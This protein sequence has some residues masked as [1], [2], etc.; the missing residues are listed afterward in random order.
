MQNVTSE[1]VTRQHEDRP[2]W[3]GNVGFSD[4]QMKVIGSI[5]AISAIELLTS[6]ARFEAIPNEHLAW[7]L[8]I[9]IT[10]VS[11]GIGFAVTAR[12]GAQA[13]DH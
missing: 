9:H 13:K 5:A 6:F 10:F 8:G 4:L 2:D 3:M 1:I 12:F 7:K 11:S